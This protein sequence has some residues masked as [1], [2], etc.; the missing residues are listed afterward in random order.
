VKPKLVLSSAQLSINAVDLTGLV[1][2]VGF[3]FDPWQV[4]VL[5]RVIEERPH[6]LAERHKWRLEFRARMNGSTAGYRDLLGPILDEVPGRSWASWR[7][8][9]SVETWQA[10]RAAGLGPQRVE[11]NLDQVDIVFGVAV[12][13]RPPS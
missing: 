12:A 5:E 11:V 6:G 4:E 8:P 1:K 3:E 10:R 13:W 9:W 7:K 2:E